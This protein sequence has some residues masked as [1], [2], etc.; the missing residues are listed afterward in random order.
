[1]LNKVA[2]GSTKWNSWKA[3]CSESRNLR[4]LATHSLQ[5]ACG[6][7]STTGLPVSPQGMVKMGQDRNIVKDCVFVESLMM[8][9]LSV[10][11]YFL[12][13]CDNE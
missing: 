9:L 10:A 3:C 11:F 8:T 12:N 4:T 7:P 5:G 13:G 2:A 6:V 1:M